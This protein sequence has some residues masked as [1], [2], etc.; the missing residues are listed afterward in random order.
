[1][2]GDWS[3]VEDGLTDTP[4]CD[5]ILKSGLYKQANNQDDE[6]SRN[7]N[8]VYSGKASLSKSPI[9]ECKD[10][11][12]IMFPVTVEEYLDASFTKQQ[13]ELVRSSLVIFPH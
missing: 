7:P 2:V 1:M 8:I 13:M 4:F 10:I 12:N 6:I 11:D 5:Y 9:Y 3:N